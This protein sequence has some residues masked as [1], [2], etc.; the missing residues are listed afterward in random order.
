MIKRRI[1]VVV[2]LLVAC[3][4]G[5]QEPVRALEFKPVEPVS[6]TLLYE[7]AVARPP[8]LAMTREEHRALAEIV[9]LIRD[10]QIEHA[11]Q[12]WSGLVSG[13]VAHPNPRVRKAPFGAVDV[14]DLFL[15]VLRKTYVEAQQ[16]L[17]DAADRVRE[18]HEKKKRTREYIDELRG[19]KN[20]LHARISRSDAPKGAPMRVMVTAEPPAGMGSPN[21]HLRRTPVRSSTTGQYTGNVPRLMTANDLDAEIAKWDEQLQT[22]GD[23]AQLANIDLQDALQKQQHLMQ[24]MSNISKVLHDTAMA[25]IRKLGG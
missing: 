13:L 3:S 25:V 5:A 10:G 16:D 18:A 19:A 20:D 7:V 6:P 23:D 1:A 15:L 14:N 11:T 12:E 21:V 4:V 8:N 24:M 9:H 22:V 17:R 2:L